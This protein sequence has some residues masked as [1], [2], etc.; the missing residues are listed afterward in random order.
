MIMT[1]DEAKRYIIENPT[2]YLTPD[3]TG[4]GYICPICGSGSGNNGTG[5]TTKDG[6]H[7]TCWA[8]CFRNSD[9]I[10]IIGLEHNITDTKEKFKKAYEVY[11]IQ[12]AQNHDKNK[13]Y[14]HNTDNTHN[15]Y[16][17]HN[18]HNKE[19]HTNKMTTKPEAKPEKNFTNLF[20]KAHSFIGN[21]TY[22][23]ER[24]LSDRVL[25][26]FNIGY[27]EGFNATKE[28]KWNAIIIPTG[29]SSYCIRN[30]DK[31]ASKE[32]RYAK[33]GTTQLFNKNA[34]HQNKPVFVVEGE[35]EAMSLVEVGAEAVA[36]GSCS[37]Y[38]RLIECIKKEKLTNTFILALDKDT[39]GE[40]GTKELKA[41]L[42]EL[43]LNFIETNFSG[44]E[45]GDANDLLI[46]DR[47]EL[48]RR[49][50]EAEQEALYLQNRHL[51]ERQEEYKK[52]SSFYDIQDFLGGIRDRA[53]T[54][55]IPTGFT[56]LDEQLD[57][58]LFEGLYFIGAISSLGKTTFTLQI[59][60]QIAKSGQDVLIFS[61]EMAKHE[62]MAK[63]I[64]R[65]TILNSNSIAEAK[66]TRGITTYKRYSSYNQSE[67]ALINTAIETYSQYSSH[68]YIIEGVGDVGAVQ[69]KKA[70]ERHIELTGNKPVVIIDYI[71][72]IAPANEGA[73]DKQNTDKAV[74]E[75]KRLS[76]DNKLSIIG[77]SSFNRDN[78]TAK[79]SM[80]AFK[81]SGAIEYSSDVLIGLQFKGQGESNFDVNKAKARGNSI[82]TPR[83]IELVILKNRNGRTGGSVFYKYYSAFNYFIEE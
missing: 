16:N 51:I 40:K 74:L 71:Q 32:D 49:V 58:G 17:T 13:Q 26:L 7:F 1:R 64:S 14:T 41:E 34:L 53:N 11:N 66:T 42:E 35:I 37:N 81:E 68:I 72:I 19:E 6:K 65:E 79:V 18:A 62:L 63:S 21:T 43:G 8:G 33:R 3:K 61:L 23:K 57:G 12:L 56:K 15:T 39:G 70:V 77:I 4:K 50:I 73:T 44:A 69:I 55:Y 2:D 78:Y 22:L 82:D 29:I 25:D 54:P 47:E 83:E 75:L 30:T 27:F 31:N 52:N 9:I 5:I 28:K 60:D 67:I 59:A 46:K 36:L 80:Q 24:G 10:D 48:K 20:T 38:P 45:G 76:R